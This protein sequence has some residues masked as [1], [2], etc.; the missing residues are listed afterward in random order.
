M[1]FGKDKKLRD[2]SYKPDVAPGHYEPLTK[3][4]KVKKPHFSF[5]Y[6][7]HQNHKFPMKPKDNVPG[8][9]AYHI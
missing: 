8:P 6:A 9:G 3:Q 7:P 4:T 1:L 5:S 2:R